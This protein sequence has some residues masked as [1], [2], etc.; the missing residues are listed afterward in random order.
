MA[1]IGKPEK[2]IEIIPVKQPVETPASTGT[3]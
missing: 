3:G 1:D 2:I